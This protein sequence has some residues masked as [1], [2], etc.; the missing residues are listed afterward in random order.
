VDDEFVPAGPSIAL[1]EARPDVV[2]L[3]RWD[4][5]RHCKEWNLDSARWERVLAG[6]LTA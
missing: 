3:E 6:F 2:T 4:T 1:A 5:A